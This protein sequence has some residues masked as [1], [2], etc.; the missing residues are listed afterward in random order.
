MISG[1]FFSLQ[2]SENP[3][4]KSIILQLS[5]KY[6]IQILLKSFLEELLEPNGKKKKHKKNPQPNLQGVFRLYSNWNTV[7]ITTET[8]VLPTIISSS[9]GPYCS[10]IFG[11][12]YCV[13]TAT[14]NLSYITNIF[15]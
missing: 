8:L 5:F 6:C 13:W 10:A 2:I 14:G 1:F 9:K 3:F 15:Y 4:L 12:S 7:K 11:Q